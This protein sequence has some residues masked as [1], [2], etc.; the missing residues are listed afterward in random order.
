[1]VVGFVAPSGTGKTTLICRLLPLLRQRGL[2]VGAIKHAHHDFEVDHPG[3]DSFRL[4]EAGAAQV[5]LVSSHRWAL[6][7]EREAGDESSLQHALDRMDSRWLDVVLVEGYRDSRYPKVELYSPEIGE[8]PV[9]PRDENVIA[10][11]ARGPLPSPTNLP[12]L[13]L[14][15]IH[16]ICSF[17][18]AR[19]GALRSQSDTR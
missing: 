17:L 18:I 10:V 12:V 7:T 15:D 3:K 5:Q 13:P 9:Y 16:R 6:V 14:D 8:A 19:L 11:A 1:M 2:R 4:R